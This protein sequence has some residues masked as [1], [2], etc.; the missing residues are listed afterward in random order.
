M[1][2][3]KRSTYPTREQLDE[4][5]AW[6]EQFNRCWLCGVENDD[7]FLQLETHEIARRSKATKSWADVRNYAATCRAC[8]CE[9]LDWL[10]AVVQ[11]ALKAEHDPDNYDR[12]FVNLLRHEAP[13]SISEGQVQAWRKFVRAI[14]K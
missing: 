11:L 1:I 7:M 14:S 5:R 13:D 3:R 12:E 6:A 8:H 4:R 2:R 10:P 9:I